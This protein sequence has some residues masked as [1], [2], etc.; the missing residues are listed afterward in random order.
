MKIKEIIQA[1][2]KD[3]EDKLKTI[4]ETLPEAKRK[5][6]RPS[7]KQKV[8][9]VD[10]ISAFDIETTRIESIDQSAMYIWQWCITVDGKAV[11]IIGR[12]WRELI[13][14]WLKILMPT[15]ESRGL[16]MMVFAH[17][18]SYEFQ[19]LSG[20]FNFYPDNVFAL[21][22][23]RVLRALFLNQTMELRCSYIQSNMSLAQFTKEMRVEHQKL[24]GEDF[25]YSEKRYSWTPLTDKQM[26]YCI[27][28]VVGLCEAIQVRLEMG[29]DTLYTIP[30][31]STGYVR[32]DVKKVVGNYKSYIM[33]IQPDFHVFQLLRWAFRGGDTHANRY[34]ANR[35]LENVKSADRSSSYPDVAVNCRFPCKR[36]NV[37]NSPSIEKVMEHMERDRAVLMK[38]AITVIRLI[39]DGEGN[40]YIARHKCQVQGGVFDNGRILSADYIVTVITDIDLKIILDMYEW[41]DIVV[42]EAY[43]SAYGKLPR[44]LVELFIQ[45]Y[46]DKTELKGVEGQELN[47]MLSKAKVN[48]IYGLMAQNPLKGEQKYN[49]DYE[50]LWEVEENETKEAYDE[51]IKKAV[52]PYQWGVWITAWARFRLHEGIKLSG[53]GFVYAD[54]DSVKY[55]G[56][57]SWDE[58]NKERMSAS[59]ESGA[60]ATDRKG[61][62]HYMGVYEPDGTYTR[63][64]TMGAKKYAYEEN[65]NL[66][67]TISGVN[68]KK[69]A[70]ELVRLEN[71]KQGFV[72]SEAGGIELKYNDHPDIEEIEIDGHKQKITRNVVIKDSTYTLGLTAEYENL[73]TNCQDKY[74]EKYWKRE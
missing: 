38:V 5:S 69:G 40:P 52:L 63:F 43:Y 51:A 34:Y 56:K 26:E 22:A 47:Y 60:Y 7:N 18:L 16:R 67:V 36:F 31:T 49:S 57:V 24:S 3:A 23:R 25:N 58:Y 61:V 53:N 19:F 45:Y 12:Y 28:D 64:C 73:L 50:T 66:G 65:E 55:L 33:D 14:L 1:A 39:D 44:P 13:R 35:I 9:Y 42:E 46:L 74:N 2:D 48:S 32:R 6:G 17:N 54:T 41:D 62:V 10:C 59:I 30:L 29:N 71:F 68:K 8:R 37:I 4:L 27:N 72:F 15:L 70:K 20:V 11:I 21:K